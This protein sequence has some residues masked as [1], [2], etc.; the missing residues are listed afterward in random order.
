MFYT[1]IHMLPWGPEL[2]DNQRL[3]RSFIIGLV[4]Y[5]FLY[6]LLP[7]DRIV[8]YS[9]ITTIARI[10]KNWFW[11]IFSMDLA[12]LGIINKSNFIK[13]Q[14][15]GWLGKTVEGTKDNQRVINPQPIVHA[16][17]PPPV[18]NKTLTTNKLPRNNSSNRKEE[19]D[20]DLLT[21]NEE[22]EENEEKD[23]NIE[24]ITSTKQSTDLKPVG[25]N[26]A[27]IENEEKPTN[28]EKPNHEGVDIDK[29]IEED[30]NVGE[31]PKLTSDNIDKYVRNKNKIQINQSIKSEDLNLG[32][33]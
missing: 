4:C 15:H 2:P 27:E 7:I 16:I 3:V 30:D 14:I 19:L 12:I 29:E 24:I 28:E 6:S 26:K 22:N 31:H 32:L 10:I 11:L 9:L 33:S 5:V 20:V 13:S 23:K 18:N 25:V 17:S 8:K 1:L 21:E